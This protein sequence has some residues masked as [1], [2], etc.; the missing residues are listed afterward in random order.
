[1]DTKITKFHL[2]KHSVLRYTLFG[3]FDSFETFVGWHVTHGSLEK[4]ADDSNGWSCALSRNL[5]QVSRVV[6]KFITSWFWMRAS[7]LTWLTVHRM[8]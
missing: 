3:G 1:V 2:R 7:Y 5:H 6:G 8:R 4:A